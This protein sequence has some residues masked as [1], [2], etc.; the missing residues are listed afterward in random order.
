MAFHCRLLF[1][2]SRGCEALPKAERGNPGPLSAVFAAL[3]PRFRG[4]DENG[5]SVAWSTSDP[6]RTF[7]AKRVRARS[8]R[9]TR[10]TRDSMLETRDWFSKP[11]ASEDELAEIRQALPST[12]PPVYF[13]LLAETNGGEGPLPVN[14]YNFVSTR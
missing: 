4:D 14:P 10:L 2:H 7:T 8:G 5:G 9:K 6:L 3:G 13:D 1:R 12:L 11:P